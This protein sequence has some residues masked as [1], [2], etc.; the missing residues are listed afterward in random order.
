MKSKYNFLYGK[1]HKVVEVEG[2]SQKANDAAAV[3]QAQADKNV[4]RVQALESVKPGPEPNQWVPDVPH[5]HIWEKPDAP[6][7]PAATAE[8]L[9]K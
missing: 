3:K 5:K 8:P 6:A 4:L 7:E 1:A 2:D 9:K